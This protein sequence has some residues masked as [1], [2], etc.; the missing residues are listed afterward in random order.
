MKKL[1]MKFFVGFRLLKCDITWTDKC[2]IYYL[3]ISFLIQLKIETNV[4][5]AKICL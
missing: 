3:F 5:T 1:M 2:L 4:V